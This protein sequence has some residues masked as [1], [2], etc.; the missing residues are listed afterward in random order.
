MRVYTVSKEE[1][2]RDLSYENSKDTEW[3]KSAARHKRQ[4][5]MAKK[6]THFYGI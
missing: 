3:K 6:S 4:S 1:Q 2:E 5:N